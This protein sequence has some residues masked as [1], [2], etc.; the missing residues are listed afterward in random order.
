[1][2]GVRYEMIVGLDREVAC[3][4]C[5]IVRRDFASSP[6][7]STQGRRP[8]LTRDFHLPQAV[9]IEQRAESRVLT[10]LLWL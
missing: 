9:W 1:M 10:H 3:N 6:V 8:K 2:A 4:R 5:H 7:F